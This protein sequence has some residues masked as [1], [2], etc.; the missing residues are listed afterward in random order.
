MSIMCNPTLAPIPMSYTVIETVGQSVNVKVY[1]LGICSE[2]YTVLLFYSIVMC[3]T[4]L[5]EL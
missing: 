2:L 5:F 3:G 4:I 1:C